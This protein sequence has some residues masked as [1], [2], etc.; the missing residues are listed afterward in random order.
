MPCSRAPGR[1]SGTVPLRPEPFRQHRFLRT[2]D[3]GFA[4]RTTLCVCVSLKLYPEG[5][6]EM[7]LLTPG[8][9]R[10]PSSLCMLLFPGLSH[11]FNLCIRNRVKLHQIFACGECNK[12]KRPFPQTRGLRPTRVTLQIWQQRS[13]TALDERSPLSQRAQGATSYCTCLVQLVDVSLVNIGS[14]F[15]DVYIGNNH[16]V[17]VQMMSSPRGSCLC[18][19]TPG[20]SLNVFICCCIKLHIK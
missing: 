10:S 14:A 18:P 5:V 4:I 11:Q 16:H 6:V 19:Q 20:Q 1:C 3:F 15:I 9:Q 2:T 12:N 8:V 17:N 7:F 13:G